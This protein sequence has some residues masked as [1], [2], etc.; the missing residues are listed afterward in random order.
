M[1]ENHVL[2]PPGNRVFSHLE[3]DGLE[4]HI[5]TAEEHREIYQRSIEKPQE[6]WAEQARNLLT[7]RKPFSIVQSG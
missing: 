1:S 7:W 3:A 5:K 6:F 4:P 2:I